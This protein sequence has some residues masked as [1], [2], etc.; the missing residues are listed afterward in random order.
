LRRNGKKGIRLRK[1][2]FMCAAVSEAVIVPVL[3]SV[4]RKWLVENITD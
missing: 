3:K 4:T 1:E 2:D